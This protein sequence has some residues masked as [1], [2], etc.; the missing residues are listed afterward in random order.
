[1]LNPFK[2]YDIVYSSKI[3]GDE[4]SE[5]FVYCINADLIIEGGTGRAIS[6]KDGR[7]VY[8]PEKDSPLP[9]E[10]EHIYPDYDLYPELTKDTAIGFLTRGCPNNCPFCIVSKKEGRIS[11]KVADLSEFWR[12]QKNI[13]IMDANLL[14]C[15]DREDLLNQLIDSKAV[16]DFKQGLDA[17][18]ITEETAKLLAKIKI[19]F[20]HFAFDLMKNEEKIIEGLRIWGGVSPVS[21]REQTVYILTNYNTTFQ[22]DLYRVQKVRELGFKLL[23]VWVMTWI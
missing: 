21:R 5:D 9:E 17:R 1:M 12:G 16:I 19:K 7:E 13:D 11:R 10:I 14:A 15:K 22:E 18:F 6:I 8:N 4:Y 20:I 2:H 23:I 3:F